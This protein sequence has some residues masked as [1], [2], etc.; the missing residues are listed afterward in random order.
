MTQRISKD[1]IRQIYALAA[2]QGLVESGNKN[3]LLHCYVEA[4]TGKTSVSTLT[5]NEGRRVI[6]GL[7]DGL[8]ELNQAENRKP[9][10]KKRKTQPGKMTS[11]QINKCWKLM[12]ELESIDPST[13]GVT[14]GERMVGAIL[15]ALKVTANRDNPFVWIDYEQGNK[16]IETLKGYVLSARRKRSKVGAQHGSIGSP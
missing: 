5:P 15:K 11:G 4:Q 16:L 2:V 6:Q 3:D 8:K 12:Y 9:V 13:A 7:R 14:V 1:D 10:G